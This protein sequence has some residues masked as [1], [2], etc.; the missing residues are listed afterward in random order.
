MLELVFP[1]LP[2]KSQ[3]RAPAAI[4]LLYCLLLDLLDELADLDPGVDAAVEER[5]GDSQGGVHLPFPSSM[6]ES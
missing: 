4:A 6:S 3:L 1:V 5:R 2:P